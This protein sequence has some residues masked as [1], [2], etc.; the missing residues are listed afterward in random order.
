M[1]D[2]MTIRQFS[3]ELASS[4]PTPGGG[5]A[6]ALSAVLGASLD[7]MVFNLTIGKKI[8]DEYDETTKELIK[9][10][11][12]KAEQFKNEFI[13]YIDKDAEAFQKISSAYKMPKNTEKQ[14][15]D[16]SKAIQAGYNAAADIPLELAQKAS[17]MYEFIKTACIYGNK[18]LVSDA[19]AAAIQIHAAIETSVLNIK[20]NLPGIKNIE[21]RNRLKNE[22]DVL[23]KLSESVKNDILKI[24]YEIINK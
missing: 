6:A 3:T 14:K 12:A 24:V 16:R 10:S 2:N 15:N 19:G 7:C 5:G 13:E 1:F 11:L 21:E 18:N 20:V 23:M 9:V 8:Y 4:A 17:K 22:A